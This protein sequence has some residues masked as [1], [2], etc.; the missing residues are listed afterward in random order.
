MSGRSAR[1][2]ADHS[3]ESRIV[4]HRGD[5]ARRLRVDGEAAEDLLLLDELRARAAHAVDD[6]IEESTWSSVGSAS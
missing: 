6:E 4:E 2:G 5:E 3:H 1:H